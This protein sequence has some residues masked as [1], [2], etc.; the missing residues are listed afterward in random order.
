MDFPNFKGFTEDEWQRQDDKDSLEM[1]RLLNAS[2]GQEAQL[3]LFNRE[4]DRGEKADDAQDY[5]DISDD[6]LPEEEAATGGRD[7]APGL[8][9]DLDMDDIGDDLFGEGPS[10]PF[11]GED[12]LDTFQTNGLGHTSRV[13]GGLTLPSLDL[14]PEVDL[15][16]LNFPEHDEEANQDLS[17]PSVPEDFSEFIQQSW[18]AFE[19]HGLLNWNQLLPPKK[20]FFIPKVPA[21]PPKP[22]NP[23]KAS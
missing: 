16:A 3:D 14:E 20:A 23:T 19:E 18:P 5:E 10:S 11:H 8:T 13:G 21:K 15:R 9:D 6:D 4:L 2:E 12:V 17:I 7:D 22:V 1:A